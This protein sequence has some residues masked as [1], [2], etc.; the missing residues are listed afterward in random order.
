MAAEETRRSTASETR[1]STA[2][3]VEKQQDGSAEPIPHDNDN[4]S[5]MKLFEIEDCF[6]SQFC[7]GTRVPCFS[8][9]CVIVL[10]CGPVLYVGV[11]WG[12]SVLI[13]VFVAYWVGF[14]VALF[15][16]CARGLGSGCSVDNRMGEDVD[17]L[18][19]VVEHFPAKINST[20][21]I[22]AIKQI[23]EKLTEAHLALFRTT[24]F[25][26]LLE[27]HELKFSGQLV[28]HLLFRQ[29]RS[30]NKSEMW[31]AI[32]GKTFPF[33]IQEFCL[34]TGLACVP[35]PPVLEKGDG[36]GSFWSSML[37]GE[38]RYNNKTLEAIFKA[39]SS[40]SDKDMVKLALLYF[41]EKISSGVQFLHLKMVYVFLAD[42]L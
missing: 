7:K 8:L 38:V 3:T 31:F 40:D 36:S 22:V 20:S 30:S 42:V 6:D 9:F 27:M 10:L 5:L 21:S 32:G 41:L 2:S 13:V 24:C 4:F 29:I 15:W 35:D 37:N 39:A 16:L 25:G 34:I 1:R 26:K 23:K 14:L 12:C 18:V 19:K 11:F 28:H 33:S 17:F